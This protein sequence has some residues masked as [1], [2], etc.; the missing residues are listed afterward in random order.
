MTFLHVCNRIK[1]GPPRPEGGP[2]SI[3]R[4]QHPQGASSFGCSIPKVQHPQGEALL[5]VSSFDVF[6]EGFKMAPSGVPNGRKLACHW[7]MC[8]WEVLLPK[9]KGAASSRC[10]ILRVQHPQGAAPLGC[11]MLRGCTILRVQHHVGAASSGCNKYG[12]SM[13]ILCSICMRAPNLAHF[14]Y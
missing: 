4:V 11:S 9:S 6:A 14:M 8:S 5:W 12:D 2:C 13:G 3:F 10:S 1:L 7:P